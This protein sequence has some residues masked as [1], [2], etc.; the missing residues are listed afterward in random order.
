[1]TYKLET[2]MKKIF[3]PLILIISVVFSGCTNN[4]TVEKVEQPKKA[5]KIE[6]T[7]AKSNCLPITIDDQDIIKNIIQIDSWDEIDELPEDLIPEFY[8]NVYQEKTE[9]LNQT[10]KEEKEFEIIETIT[11][12]EDYSYAKV[13]VSPDVIK[14][15]EVKDELLT[16]YYT[17]PDETFDDIEELFT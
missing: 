7:S 17:T 12:Y 10:S 6:V 1:M 11:T 8:I 16:F 4:N 13:S 3:F 15:M 14:N 5:C 9:Q 2:E